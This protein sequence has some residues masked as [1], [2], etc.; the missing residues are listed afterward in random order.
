MPAN[1]S[2]EARP[3]PDVQATRS[4]ERLVRGTT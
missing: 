4:G 1:G 3:D 2:F